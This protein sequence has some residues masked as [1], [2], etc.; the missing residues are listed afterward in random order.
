MAANGAGEDRPPP[1]KGDGDSDQASGDDFREFCSLCLECYQGRTPKILPCFHT[2]CLP[3][4]TA[5]VAAI[6]AKAVSDQ[7]N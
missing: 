7:F 2:F 1:G 4:L 5:L 3:C 6:L